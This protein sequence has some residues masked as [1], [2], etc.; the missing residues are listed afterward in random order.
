L[1]KGAPGL[2]GRKEKRSRHAYFS[3]K[4]ERHPQAKVGNVALALG[5]EVDVYWGKFWGKVSKMDEK[6][7]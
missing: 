4:W 2:R 3:E 5:A 6:I 7:N 1:V